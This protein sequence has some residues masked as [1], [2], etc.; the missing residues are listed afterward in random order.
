MKRAY[1]LFVVA[2][3]ISPI[4]SAQSQLTLYQL[5]SQL[6]QAN[7]INAG[8]FPE[9]KITV[10]LPVI[11]SSY[12]SANGG[13]LSF[14]RAFTRSS[15]DS[16]HL[17]PQQLSTYLDKNN[18]LETSANVQL[19]SF[20]LRLKKNYFSLTLN[21]RVEA[22]FTY[23]KTFVE[24]L[25]NGNGEKVGELVAFDKF[26]MRAMAYH[27]LAVG[28]GREITDKLSVGIRAKF[29]SGIVN[30]DLESLSAAML[31]STDS[32]YLYSPAFNINTT[33][34]DLL[35]NSGDIFSAATAF[36]NSGFAIDLGAQYWINDK[37]R[38]SLAVNDL[39]S[40][41][42]Q[43]DT[44]Q[45]QFKEVKYS[46]TGIDF[47]TLL[48]QSGNADLLTQELDS[49]RGLYQPDTVDGISYKTGLSPS[50]Y[51]AGSYQLN[52]NHTFGAIFYG[53]IFKGTF[54]P[55]FGLS[56]NLQL[57]HIWTIGVNASFRN[58]TFNNFGVGT[59]IT[60]GPVQIYVL[61]ENAAAFANL[62]DAR[63][64]DARVGMNLVFGNLARGPKQ[65]KHKKEK[66]P[67]VE[68]ELVASVL[69]ESVTTVIIGSHA[70][71]LATGFYIVIASFTAKEDA[72]DYSYS[73]VEQG[74]AALSGYQSEKDKYYTY[75]MY[76]PED[77][78]R[79]IDK[80]NDLQNS[81]A[82]GLDKPWVLWV[83][84]VE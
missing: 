78:N 67:A 37:I 9:Y 50:I 27:E 5:N 66:Q 68:P 16:L 80:K 56:Y 1:F 48:D 33:G 39:G 35:E 24:L 38:V 15:D 29:L 34:L 6:P 43:N 40:I 23:P 65:K 52:K 58:N 11:S 72:E 59:T 84:E 69:S 4:L 14:N 74:Y 18:R 83:K 51:A 32:I 2:F 12:F 62:S 13:Q 76:Y 19:F 7:Q 8:L 61:T 53:D 81:F 82:P 21:E 55:A 60:L 26:G 42:W 71:E 75:L 30:A 28:Y 70:D 73:L 44:R 20:G 49:L 10:G 77:G 3:F 17:N 31:T 63:F 47:L 57:G 22:G 79:A 25:A 46:F 45:F 54:K 36:N 64:I 41:N